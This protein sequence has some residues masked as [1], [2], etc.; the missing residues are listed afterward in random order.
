MNF[1]KSVENQVFIGMI[2]GIPTIGSIFKEKEYLSLQRLCIQE[3][4]TCIETRNSRENAWSYVVM[5]E[6]KV[7][8]LVIEQ[9]GNLKIQV[10]FGTGKNKLTLQGI[11]KKGD[12]YQEF[13]RGYER[14]QQVK[15][16]FLCKE[17]SEE[18]EYLGI[19]NINIVS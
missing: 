13:L 14:I 10:V 9:E 19:E 4:T 15:I 11:I 5:P 17:S 7:S 8:G 1:K 3:I 2:D 6:S 12:G 16:L 18:Y